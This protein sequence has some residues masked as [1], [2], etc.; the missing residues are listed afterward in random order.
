MKGLAI[1][2]SMAALAGCGGM[3]WDAEDKRVGHTQGT[4]TDAATGHVDPVTGEPVAADS[5]WRAEHEGRTYYFGDRD[6]YQKFMDNPAE[7]AEPA[8]AE[9]R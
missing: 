4:V 9:V 1:A 5:P 7:Y 8:E 3:D 6:S 2:L